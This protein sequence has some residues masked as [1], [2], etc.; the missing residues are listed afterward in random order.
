LLTL[1]EIFFIF[2]NKLTDLITDDCGDLMCF[3]LFS[4]SWTNVGHMLSAAYCW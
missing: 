3:Q 4:L 2:L 1:K